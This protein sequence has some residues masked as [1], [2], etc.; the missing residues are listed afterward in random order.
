MTEFKV[1]D[2]IID[3]VQ[4]Y[5]DRAEVNRLI[6]LSSLDLTQSGEHTLT[7]KNISKSVYDSSIR[8]KGNN[9]IKILEV[10]IKT[11]VIPRY[12][13]E[14]H[15]TELG[16]KKVAL[17]QLKKELESLSNEKQ[18]LNTNKKFLTDYAESCFKSNQ[19]VP[20]LDIEKAKKTLEY[21]N[22]ET[23]QC[24]EAIVKLNQQIAEKTAEYEVLKAEIHKFM[25]DTAEFN[26]AQ[27]RTICDRIES[28]NV[29]DMSIDFFDSFKVEEKNVV[30]RIEVI[31]QSGG[32][33][34][35]TEGEG[36]ASAIMLTYLVANAS[37]SASYD[38]RLDTVKNKMLISYSASIIQKTGE[39][40]SDCQLSLST[41]NPGIGSTPE[42]LPLR[43]VVHRDPYYDGDNIYNGGGGPSNFAMESAPYSR[44]LPTMR[45]MKKKGG[46]LQSSLQQ[47]SGAYAASDSDDEEEDRTSVDDMDMLD[48]TFAQTTDVKGSGDALSAVFSIPRRVDISSDGTN[49][50]VTIGTMVLVPNLVYYVAPSVSNSVY[51]Q[52]RAKN[53]STYTLLASSKVSIFMDGSFM[54]TG[55]IRLVCPGDK[56]FMSVGVDP[57]IK[58]EYKAIPSKSIESSGM[59]SAGTK[60]EEKKSMTIIH[61]A[62]SSDV[63]IYMTDAIPSTKIEKVSVDLIEPAKKNVEKAKAIDFNATVETGKELIAYNTTQ[64]ALVWMLNVAA[65]E[66]RKVDFR[67]SITSPPG[68]KLEVKD[69]KGEKFSLDV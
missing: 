56:F 69:K 48:D 51:L 47:Q 27:A 21:Y 38:V 34:E 61:N 16:Q 66:K 44:P 28:S 25:T 8:V 57:S 45:V 29:A 64:T 33:K 13:S 58:A 26:N 53:T 65:G 32:E 18:R 31:G 30:V 5:Y 2:C 24:T 42:A 9:R 1:K 20:P 22:D 59:F 43:E 35:S 39:A 46:R 40:W 10:G 23:T 4:L 67:Y 12:L 6:D 3:N 62:K 55:S 41:S 17:L 54:S 36:D 50:N 7:L 11:Q 49:H 52:A 19:G 37:W 15:G 68:T 60:V 14:E 63:R